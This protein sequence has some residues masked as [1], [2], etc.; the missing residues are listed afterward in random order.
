M[1]LSATMASV[2]AERKAMIT[3][4]V[5]EARTVAATVEC[6]ERCA[7]AI[8]NAVMQ[9]AP[10]AKRIVVAEATDLDDGLFDSCRQLAG[11]FNE[12][13]RHALSGADVG[14]TDAFAA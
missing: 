8:A 2:P 9:A 14:V 13:T 5:E 7:T 12:R 1:S 3:R 4:F 10:G 11:V 6:V